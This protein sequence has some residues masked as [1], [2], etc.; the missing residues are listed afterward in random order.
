MS[1]NPIYVLNCGGLCN[2]LNNLI[3]GTYVSDILKRKMIVYWPMNQACWCKVDELFQNQFNIKYF[4]NWEPETMG[5]YIGLFGNKCRFYRKEWPP[6]FSDARF[7]RY[8][9]YPGR[10]RLLGAINKCKN[11]VLLQGGTIFDFIPANQ[12]LRILRELVPAD[13]VRH[14]VDD[15]VLRNNLDKRIMGMHVRQT[16]AANINKDYFVKKL[17]ATFS[18]RPKKRFFVC[19]DSTDLE[20]EL[21]ERFGDNVIINPKKAYPVRLDSNSGWITEVPGSGKYN[22]WRSTDSV[23]EALTDLYLLAKTRFVVRSHG[24]FSNIGYY[25]SLVEEFQ[26]QDKV[27]FLTRLKIQHYNLYQRI[28]FRFERLK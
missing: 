25:L 14:A 17:E 10:R 20:H 12:R 28:I 19:S 2:R 13:D 5:D 21:R 23:K 26:G 1:Y 15:F 22:V 8:D 18:K 6:G 24:S 3:N 16:D 9:R 11:G 7:S 4:D 27:D